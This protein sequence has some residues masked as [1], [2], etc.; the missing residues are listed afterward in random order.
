MKDEK[1]VVLGLMQ[2]MMRITQYDSLPF[3]AI[4]SLVQ[5]LCS[6]QEYTLYTQAQFHTH[7]K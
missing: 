5:L 7:S 1:N 2:F 3:L 4:Q 6:Q